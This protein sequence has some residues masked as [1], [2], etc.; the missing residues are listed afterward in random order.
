MSSIYEKL[1]S[2]RRLVGV[3]YVGSTFDITGW[4]G[5]IAP[6]RVDGWVG[7]SRYAEESPDAAARI[8]LHVRLLIPRG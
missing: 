6:V 2:V 1:Q 7:R 5:F 3:S 8:I 4:R